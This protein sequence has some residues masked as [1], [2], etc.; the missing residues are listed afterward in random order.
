MVDQMF[1]GGF[2]GKPV[3]PLTPPRLFPAESGLITVQDAIFLNT[4]RVWGWRGSSM[5]LASARFAAGDDLTPERDW[6]IAHGVNII[7]NFSCGVG[8]DN[9]YLPG[10]ERLNFTRPF[11]D[12]N[13][14]T[15]LAACQSFFADGGIRM[16]HVCVTD[17]AVNISDMRRATQMVYEVARDSDLL[18]NLT[19]FVE[20]TNE[21][22]VLDGRV[23][24]LDLIAG[25]N[26]YRGMV[27]SAYGIQPDGLDASEDFAVC[28]TLDYGTC[29]PPRDRAHAHNGRDLLRRTQAN[30]VPWIW[31]EPLGFADFDR[32]GGGMRTSDLDWVVSEHAVARLFGAGQTMHCQAGLEGRRPNADEPRTEEIASAITVMWAFI[33][34]DC[35]TGRYVRAGNPDFPAEYVNGDSEVNHAYGSIHGDVAYLVLPLPTA[36]WQGWTGANGWRLDAVGPRS[37]IARFVR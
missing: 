4:G 32:S 13:F 23:L 28:P 37:Y 25:V 24:P 20:D 6:C 11:D 7:R 21:P 14:Q 1:S 29:H 10:V 17:R 27:L 33:P 12:P 8:W 19:Q 9:D 15:S 35:Y 5:F 30:P 16:E 2:A 34:D 26:P 22:W 36:Q 18:R 31:D 3:P